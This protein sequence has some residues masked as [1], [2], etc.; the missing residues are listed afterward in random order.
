MSNISVPVFFTNPGTRKVVYALIVVVLLLVGS[1]LIMGQRADRVVL[2]TDGTAREY[3]LFAGNVESLLKRAGQEITD[4]DW[5]SRPLT[6]TLKDGDVVEVKKAFLISV[7]ADG[8]EHI[9]RAAGVTV[10]ELLDRAGISL[11]PLDRVE[12]D[13]NHVVEKGDVVRVTRVDKTLA[14]TRTEIPFREIRKSN[15]AL[16]RGETR[17]VQKGVNGLREDTVEVTLEDGVEVSSQVLHS[18]IITVRQDRIVEA[19]E[20]TQLSRGGRTLQFDRV[21]TVTAT[22]YCPGTPGSGCPIDH[23]GQS[24]C[25]GKYNDGITYTGRKAVA[26]DG[27]ETN[28]HIIAVDPRRI[29]L[30]SRVYI[31]GYGFAVAADIGS[32]IKGNRI[33][34]LFDKHDDAWMFGRKSLKVYLL[35]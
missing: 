29:P 30:G 27:S 24:K 9:I 25:T 11:R 8:N 5:I 7:W 10:A 28:P 32:A 2:V 14:K 17:V 34:L 12:P 35:T 26:G 1:Q 19:G 13:L 23:N 4:S 31:E 6:D 16:D 33:D 22:A 15:P 3:I 21:V 20:N 18:E